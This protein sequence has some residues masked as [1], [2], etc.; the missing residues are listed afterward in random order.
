[1]Y[2]RQNMTR[3]SWSCRSMFTLKNLSIK[4]FGTRAYLFSPD[5]GSCYIFSTR[6]NCCEFLTIYACFFFTLRCICIKHCIAHLLK[7]LYNLNEVLSKKQKA[8]QEIRGK[9]IEKEFVI[10]WKFL[11]PQLNEIF[12]INLQLA[13]KLFEHLR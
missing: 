11:C 10:E 6:C 3:I 13:E 12:H 4:Y 9:N 2:V 7:K 8:V 1:M 5:K